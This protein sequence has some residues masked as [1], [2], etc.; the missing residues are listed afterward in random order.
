[1]RIRWYCR[2]P[3]M[4]LLLLFEY[5]SLREDIQDTLFEY[6]PSSRTM[7]VDAIIRLVVWV[8]KNIVMR[9]V[10]EVGNLMVSKEYLVLVV[11]VTPEIKQKSIA[12]FGELGLQ[13]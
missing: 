5:A 11:T 12:K 13:L 2:A 9:V 8:A 3:F 6:F 10:K 4:N 7:H 1:M